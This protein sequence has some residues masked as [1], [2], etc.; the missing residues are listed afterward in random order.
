MNATVDQRVKS[1]EGRFRHGLI[2]VATVVLVSAVGLALTVSVVRRMDERDKREDARDA[3][4]DREKA[5]RDAVADDQRAHLLELVESQHECS[6]PAR[7]GQHDPEPAPHIHECWDEAAGA[8]LKGQQNQLD[9][10]LRSAKNTETV[11]NFLNSPERQRSVS[12]ALRQ[13]NANTTRL[14]DTRQFQVV[15]PSRPDRPPLIVSPRPAP[16]PT[17][18]CQSAIGAGPINV[19]LCP[20]PAP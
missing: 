3:I 1:L 2:I 16:S 17:S 4:D 14:F 6:S 11:V 8:L 12:E 18:G 10:L 9:T 7:P 5:E 15:D 20:P 19:E 13:I